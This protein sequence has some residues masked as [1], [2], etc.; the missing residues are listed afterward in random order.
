MRAA[1]SDF[2]Q[3]FKF[4]VKAT[5]INEINPLNQSIA[6][7]D[8]DMTDGAAEA[9]FMSVTT[10]EL[11]V[12]NVE[13]RE[14]TSKWTQKYPGIPTVSDVSLMRGVVKRDTDFYDMVMD[15]I[16]GKD[17]RADVT[18]LMYQRSEMGSASKATFPEGAR[19]IV[20]NN[21]FAIRAKVN[22]DLDSNT[23]D[24]SQCEADLAVESFD[25]LYA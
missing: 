21:A 3:N 14:G 1:S 17:Y 10:P 23:S 15:G 24:I 7:V 6:A 12:E 8:V 25:V 19:R 13:Y 9:G 2:L 22:S 4:H 11:T 20:C 18:I 5:N 16:N